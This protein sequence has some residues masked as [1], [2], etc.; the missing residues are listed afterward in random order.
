MKRSDHEVP[1]VEQ[2]RTVAYC[3]A[4]PVKPINRLERWAELLETDPK[5]RLS[6]LRGTEWLSPERRDASRAEGSAIALA[7]EDPIL[8]AEGLQDDTYGEAKRFFGLRDCDMHLILCYCHYGESTSAHSA[9][10][11]VRSVM[12]AAKGGFLTKI[13]TWLSGH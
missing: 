6:T 10:V 11:A 12:S 5:R 9:A 2:L 13:K 3:Q 1:D 4:H 8:R 7:L